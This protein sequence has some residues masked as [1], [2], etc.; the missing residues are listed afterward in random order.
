[1]WRQDNRRTGSDLD[2][3][4]AG[5]IDEERGGTERRRELRDERSVMLR[6]DEMTCFGLERS[7]GGVVE[8]GA[9]IRF[10]MMRIARQRQFVLEQQ[11]VERKRQQQINRRRPDSNQRGRCVPYRHCGHHPK[12]SS[13]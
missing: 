4:T 5:R 13:A 8:P 9:E 12:N 1:M 3:G 10:A 7:A 11:R 6:D 2:G